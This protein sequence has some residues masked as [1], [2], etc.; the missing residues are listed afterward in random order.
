MGRFLSSQQIYNAENLT[1]AQFKKMFGSAIKKKGYV[2]CGEDSA[3]ISYTLVFSKDRKWVSVLNTEYQPGAQD[4]LEDAGI[5]AENLKTNVVSVGL[6]DSDF[7]ELKLFDSSGK[8]ADTLILGESYMDVP[9]PNGAKDLWQPLLSANST[10]KQV[11][12]IQN[13]SYTFAEDALAEFAQLMGMDGNQILLDNED[14]DDGAAVMYFKKAGK[15][16]L[17]LNAAFKQ[18]FGKA[19]EPLGF[20]KIKSK[21]PYYVRAVT[22]EI[23][24]IVTIKEEWSGYPTEKRFN[25]YSGIATVYRYKID[26]DLSMLDN[27]EWLITTDG[28]YCFTYKNTKEYDEDFQHSIFEY[29]YMKNNAES[30]LD[31]M[32]YAL[33][34]TEKFVIPLFN[35]VK[36]LKDCVDFFRKYNFYI[37][38]S[39]FK[40]DFKFDDSVIYHDEG[41]LYVK[42]ND[43]RLQSV[44]RKGLEE[45]NDENSERYQRLL[46][47]LSFFDEPDIHEKVLK[48]LERRKTYNT[49]L[50]KNYGVCI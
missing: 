44:L 23:I 36:S 22:D 9:S 13:G 26:F 2:V 17:T 10:W 47:K 25:I 15:K 43:E 46:E 19:L 31:S 6:V 32:Q 18:V 12:E 33:E 41:L 5:F 28:L 34:L 50:L 7:A 45:E 1:K 38:T 14:A 42:S 48:E 40:R 35:N 8:L 20:V 16:S 3:E 4:V 29:S 27:K 21:H 11:T 37:T 30:L 49:E 39:T 24:N